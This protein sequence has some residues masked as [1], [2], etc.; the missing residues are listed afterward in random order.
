M[1]VSSEERWFMYNG[2]FHKYAVNTSRLAGYD[3]TES[4]IYNILQTQMDVSSE[5]RWFMYNGIFHKYAVNT[6]RPAGYDHA[7]QFMQSPDNDLIMRKQPVE[8]D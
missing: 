4:A 7:D 8:L 5:E 2:I 3:H 6:S 1:G